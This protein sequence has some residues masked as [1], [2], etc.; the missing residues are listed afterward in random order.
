MD[1]VP[2]VVH[3]SDCARVEGEQVSSVGEDGEE[4]TLCDVLT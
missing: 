4:K 3:S 1:P 2:E